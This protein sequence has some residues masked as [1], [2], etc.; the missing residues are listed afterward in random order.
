NLARQEL[1]FRRFYSLDEILDSIQAV[2]GEQLQSLARQYFRAEDTAV[3]VLGNLNG[4]T[5]DRA[6]LAC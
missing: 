6:R 1:Y 3:T 4:F 5:L 2:T